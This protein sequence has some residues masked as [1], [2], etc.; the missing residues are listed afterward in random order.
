MD[1]TLVFWFFSHAN[2]SSLFY[3]KVFWIISVKFREF[4]ILLPKD[5]TCVYRTKNTL[6]CLCWLN[7]QIKNTFWTLPVWFFKCLNYRISIFVASLLS[8]VTQVSVKSCSYKNMYYAFGLSLL[9]PQSVGKKARKV[10][11][12][13]SHIYR[14]LNFVMFSVADAYY[15]DFLYWFKK[16]IIIVPVSEYPHVNQIWF[17]SPHSFNNLSNFACVEFEAQHYSDTI[18]QQNMWEI[19]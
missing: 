13:M 6:S 9:T 1:I 8:A 5:I 3:F 15:R 4:W 7:T 12:N 14:S 10:F 18:G 2:L 17:V 16:N 19:K 11:K